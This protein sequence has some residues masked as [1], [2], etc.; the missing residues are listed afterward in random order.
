MRLRFNLRFAV[1]VSGFIWARF[2]GFRDNFGF[3]GEGLRLKFEGL[4]LRHDQCCFKDTFAA[5]KRGSRAARLSL[6]RKS[7]LQNTKDTESAQKF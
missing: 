3:G 7:K 2:S 6:R 5:T 4:G 1:Q